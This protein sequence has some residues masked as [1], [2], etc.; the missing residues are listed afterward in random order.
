[1]VKVISAK[2]MNDYNVYIKFNDGIDGILDFKNILEADHRK[3][4]RD[5]LDIEM[6]KTVKVN[7]NTLYWDNDVDFAPD[8][9]YEKI[10]KNINVA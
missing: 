10:V 5:L 4:V 7:L 3:I 9:L 1:M 2:I 8:Y 6:F